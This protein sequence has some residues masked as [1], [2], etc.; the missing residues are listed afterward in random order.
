MNQHYTSFIKLG[1]SLASDKGLTWDFPISDE[2]NAVDGIGW[3]LTACIGD[4]PPPTFYLRDLGYESK[5]IQQINAERAAENLPVLP[6]QRLSPAWQDL[7]KAAVSE[8][9]FFKRNSAA[10][11][12]SQIARPLRILAT[13]TQKEPWEITLDDLQYSVRIASIIQTSGKLSEVVAGIV[14]VILDQYHICDAGQMYSML[15]VKRVALKNVKSKHTMSEDELR[16]N[17]E[18]RKRAERLPSKQAFWELVRIVM[19]ERPRTFMDELRFAAVKTMIFT[20]LRAGEIVLLPIDWKRERTYLDAKKQPAGKAGGFSSALLLRHF[21]EKQQEEE[22]DSRILRVNVQPIPEMFRELLTD[23]LERV[24]DITAPLRETLKLQCQSGRLL[25]WYQKNEL[26]PFTQLYTHITGNPFW[27]AIKREPFLDEYRLNFDAAILHKLHDFQ[28]T[29][30][31]V[32]IKQLDMSIYMFGNRLQKQMDSKATL[33]TYRTSDGHPISANAR[34]SW[35][36]TYLH[37][38]ELE[39]HIRKM[40]PTKISDTLPLPAETGAIQPWELLFMH[41]KRSLAEERNEGLCDITRYIAVSRPDPTLIGFALGGQNQTPSL[42]AQYGATEEDRN[43]KLESHKLRHL[44]NTELFRLGVADT[45]ISKRFNRRSVAQS[46]EYDHRSLAEDLEQISIPEEI[47]LMLGE[48]ATTVAKMI[49]AG[50]A[51]GP[52]VEAFLRIQEKDGDTSAYEYLRVEA[53][54]FHATPYG[55]CLNSFTVDPCPKHL[56]CFANCRHLSATDLPE[57]K[58]NL[59]RLEEKFKVAIETIRL[60]PS[61]SIGWRNQLQHAEERL[62]GVQKL[63]ATSPGELVFPDG[64]DLSKP[65]SRTVV[66]E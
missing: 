57:N 5:A 1:K 62:S 25:P 8:Q 32:S 20:G 26:V 63:L 36:E 59:V 29:Q 47:E 45:I 4:V 11:V 10:H 51:N 33:L 56:E 19:T 58:K 52:I 40:T 12:A 60:R 41:P 15:S 54:G 49:K 35:G 17:L 21:A 9:L 24:A 65:H 6:R 46:Y 13:C 23:T 7:M 61:T 16:T 28:K 2:G 30:Y 44:Q 18:D 22:S 38:G 43:L 37:I 55:H 64:V 31:S 3:N 53:D 39:D 34:K 48:K 66:D 14:K 27:L 50:K 42:F